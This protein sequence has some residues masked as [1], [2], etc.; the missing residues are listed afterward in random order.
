MY[1]ICCSG[2]CGSYLISSSNGDLGSNS[3][4][5]V[6]L[7]DVKSFRPNIISTRWSEAQ[8]RHNSSLDPAHHKEQSHPHDHCI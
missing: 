5:G 6:V 3:K 7:G 8:T 1:C 4:T 2:E